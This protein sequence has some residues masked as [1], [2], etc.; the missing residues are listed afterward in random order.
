MEKEIYKGSVSYDKSNKTFID[1]E[2]MIQIDSMLKEMEYCIGS[3]ASDK[4]EFYYRPKDDS[5]WR[6]LQY[7]T[8]DTTLERVTREHIEKNFPYV[9]LDNRKPVHWLD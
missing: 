6:Y 3:N 2:G 4:G 7:E 9:E 5:W 8:Y 1:D